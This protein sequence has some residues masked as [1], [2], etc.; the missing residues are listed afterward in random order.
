[1]LY[2][3]DFGIPINNENLIEAAKIRNEIIEEIK[4]IGG[5]EVNKGC[6]FGFCDAQL[7]V[8]RNK[9]DS[10]V[11]VFKRLT[12]K[13]HI[14]ISYDIDVTGQAYFGFYES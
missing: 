5:R 10:Y 4:D 13:Y 8:D 6:G 14:N 7:T 11:E 3:F 12:S 2:I 9:K 1:M